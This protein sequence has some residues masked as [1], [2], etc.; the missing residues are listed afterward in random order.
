MSLKKNLNDNLKDYWENLLHQSKSLLGI[1]LPFETRVSEIYFIFEVIPAKVSKGLELKDWHLTI[2]SQKK[3]GHQET[4]HAESHLPTPS[5]PDR[6]D[7][8]AKTAVIERLD[9]NNPQD[10]NGFT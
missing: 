10:T 6:T 5:K 8:A 4:L 9:Y 7:W 2:C 3:Q 1:T